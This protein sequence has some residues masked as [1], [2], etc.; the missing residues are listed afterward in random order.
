MKTYQDLLDIMPK[1]DVKPY[2]ARFESLRRLSDQ[3]PARQDLLTSDDQ[4]H[5]Q[6]CLQPADTKP[7]KS[8]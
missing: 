8:A 4:P 6:A 1:V 2:G 7:K 5:L 3:Q